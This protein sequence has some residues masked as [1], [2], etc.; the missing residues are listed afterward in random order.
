MDI[1]ELET[2]EEIVKEEDSIEAP[3]VKKPRTQKQIDAFLKVQE[4]RDANRASRKVEKEEATQIAKSVTEK[5]IVK[6]AIALKKKEILKEVIL[7]DMSS[8]DDVP[9][10]VIKKLQKKYL[11]KKME[12]PVILPEIPKITYKFI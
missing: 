11:R 4:K 1:Q 12:A 6:K 10:E 7:D 5:K 8:D 2:L 3:K 9:M